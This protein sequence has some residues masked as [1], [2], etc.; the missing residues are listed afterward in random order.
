MGKGFL[1]LDEKDWEDATPEQQSWMIFKTLRNMD[2]RLER[3][4]HWNR[5]M[6]FFG[7]LLGGFIA[8]IGMRWAG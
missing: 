1:I 3:L 4:E 5:C 2:Q 6:S 8:A 7:G